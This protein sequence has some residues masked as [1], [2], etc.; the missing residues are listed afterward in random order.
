MIFDDTC[1]IDACNYYGNNYEKKLH[2]FNFHTQHNCDNDKNVKNVNQICNLS[3]LS[4]FNRE[5]VVILS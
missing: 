1:H 2:L 5:I 3:I 4:K